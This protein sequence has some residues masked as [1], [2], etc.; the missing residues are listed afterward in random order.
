MG[1][2]C[3]HDPLQA[4]MTLG[5]CTLGAQM[6]ILLPAVQGAHPHL[7]LEIQPDTSLRASLQLSFHTPSTQPPITKPLSVPS[8]GLLV[9]GL[10]TFLILQI[11]AKGYLPQREGKIDWGP[12]IE[13]LKFPW[14]R[15]F[16]SENLN[17]VVNVQGPN[18]CSLKWT[19]DQQGQ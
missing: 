5:V 18:Q 8:P 19:W 3:H 16:Y 7:P 12:S 11:P 1:S 14:R 10:V 2:D 13:N 4:I 15:N 17:K 9:A 6:Y